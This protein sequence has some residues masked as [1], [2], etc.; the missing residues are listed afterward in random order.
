MG[1]VAVVV[2]DVACDASDVGCDIVMAG[3]SSTGETVGLGSEMGW[4]VAS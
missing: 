2:A 4:D 1:V 3:K